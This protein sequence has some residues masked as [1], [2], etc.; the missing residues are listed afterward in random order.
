MVKKKSTVKKVSAKKKVVKKSAV[1]RKTAVKKKAA[2]KKKVAGKKKAALKTTYISNEERYR[3]VAE[4]AY[5]LSEKQ[6]FNPGHDMDNW[7]L[8][9]TEI[10]SLMQAK[11]IQV[12]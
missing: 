5:H 6:G 10:E 11:N 2:T 3:M 8:A 4:A 9:E 12:K 1:K 7:L